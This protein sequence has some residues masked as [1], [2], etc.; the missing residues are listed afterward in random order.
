MRKKNLLFKI[1]PFLLLRIRSR[2]RTLKSDPDPVK[3]SGSATLQLTTGRSMT[4]HSGVR[5]RIQE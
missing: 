4:A 3:S 2:I 1:I 5:I